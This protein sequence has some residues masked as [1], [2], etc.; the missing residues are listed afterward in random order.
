MAPAAPAAPAAT[1]GAAEAAV[2]SVGVVADCVE[3][4]AEWPRD[5]VE[6]WRS[7]SLDARDEAAAPAAIPT[8]AAPTAAAATVDADV[9]DVPGVDADGPVADSATEGAVCVTGVTGVVAGLKGLTGSLKGSEWL[10][11]DF[12]GVGGGDSPVRLREATAAEPAAAL[13][14]AAVAGFR[15]PEAPAVVGFK[16]LLPLRSGAN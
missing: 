16:A 2:A 6:W 12:G 4:V 8:A 9:P 11:A 10:P 1:A 15:A 13:A 3:L 14:T 7:E 5:W